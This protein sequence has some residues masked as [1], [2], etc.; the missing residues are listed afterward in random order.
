MPCHA[1]S[2]G[3]LS[4]NGLTRGSTTRKRMRE[5]RVCLT[6]SPRGHRCK[7]PRSGANGDN[8]RLRQLPSSARS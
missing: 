2:T 4:R 7:T 8:T 1:T 3:P 5:R 6:S